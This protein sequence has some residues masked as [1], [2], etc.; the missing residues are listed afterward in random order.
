MITYIH[1]QKHAHTSTC[2]S[3]VEQNSLEYNVAYQNEPQKDS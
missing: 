2:L 1:T 3:D